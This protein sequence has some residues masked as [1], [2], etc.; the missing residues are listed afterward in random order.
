MDDEDLQENKPHRGQEAED[1]EQERHTEHFM[2]PAL[3]KGE[4]ARGNKEVIDE[5]E[6]RDWQAKDGR[7]SAGQNPFTAASDRTWW[8]DVLVMFHGQVARICK[9]DEGYE[10]HDDDE[11]SGYRLQPPLEPVI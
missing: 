10:D 2:I 8:N 7:K 4:Q 6:E 1:G 9:A 11:A 5:A 3:E